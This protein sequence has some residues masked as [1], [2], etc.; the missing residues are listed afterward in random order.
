MRVASGVATLGAGA[1][2]SKKSLSVALIGTDYKGAPSIGHGA[3]FA[4]D[5]RTRAP[6]RAGD[7]AFSQK[8]GGRRSLWIVICFASTEM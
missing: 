8:L 2:G 7:Q 1:V 6:H 4:D 3:A 5:L